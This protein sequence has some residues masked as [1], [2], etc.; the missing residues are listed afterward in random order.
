MIS[1]DGQVGGFVHLPNI[2]HGGEGDKD[3]AHRAKK[4]PYSPCRQS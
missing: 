3:P 1:D 4:I 2:A